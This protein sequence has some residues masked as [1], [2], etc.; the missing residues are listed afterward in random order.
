MSHKRHTAPAR[1]FTGDELTAALVGI[2]VQLAAAPLPE[3]PIEDVLVAASL[4]GMQ[5]PDLRLLALVATWLSVH[6]PWVNVDRLFR[7]AATIDIP[8][9]RAWWAAVGRWLQSD[10]RY[11]RLEGLYAGPRIPLSGAA[12]AFLVKRDGEDERFAGG[13]LIVPASTLRDRPADVLSPHQLAKRHTTYH[14]RVLMG[15]SYRADMWAALELTPDIPP[16]ELA[17]TTYGSFATAWHVKRDHEL[18]VA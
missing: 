3:P 17:R 8:E 11:R 13:P 1:L 15:P 14:W 5:G 16:A 2:G 9:V 4:E 10:R 18:L 6:H 7:A 12:T